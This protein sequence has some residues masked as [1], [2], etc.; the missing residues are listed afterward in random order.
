[1]QAGGLTTTLGKLGKLG[2]LGGTNVVGTG[3]G[4]GTNAQP[5]TQTLNVKCTSDGEVCNVPAAL[6]LP[7]G[8]WSVQVAAPSAHCSAIAY[9]VTTDNHGALIGDTGA[10]A[11][12]AFGRVMPIPPTAHQIYVTATGI[13]GGCNSGQLS[14]WSVI[15]RLLPG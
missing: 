11:P 15:V 6:N 8:Q 2:K 1:L 9:R 10:L 7:A 14:A 13:P 4:A 12:G 3:T 5:I